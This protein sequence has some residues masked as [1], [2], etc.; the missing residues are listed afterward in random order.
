MEAIEIC[1]LS[2]QAV[3]RLL[4]RR[5]PCTSKHRA[6]GGRRKVLRW[7]FPGT[8]ELWIPQPDGSERYTLATSLNLSLQ[9]V[10]IRCDEPLSPCLELGI[11]IHEPE[12]SFHGHAVVR[13]CMEIEDDYL[14]GLQ[15]LFDDDISSNDPA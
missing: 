9:G 4:E 14:I 8:V 5:A 11:A 6:G 1:R 7:P 12:A 10:G 3:A 15:F 13:H 2:E